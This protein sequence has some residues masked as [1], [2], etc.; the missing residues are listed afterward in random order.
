MATKKATASTTKKRKEPRFAQVL[1]YA[2]LAAMVEETYT[3]LQNGEIDR[4]QAVLEV[5][6]VLVPFV[7]G[8]KDKTDAAMKVRED[9]ET[10][11]ADLQV[12]RDS[13]EK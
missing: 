6:T 3:N 8:L 10:L 2:A 7:P 9:I 11:I 5:V 12:L 13:R 4:E 1:K